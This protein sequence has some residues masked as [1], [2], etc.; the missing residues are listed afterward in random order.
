LVVKCNDL[1]SRL[2]VFL[3]DE[4]LDLLV[5]HV[6]LDPLLVEASGS[7]VEGVR[8]LLGTG[9]VDCLHASHTVRVTEVTWVSDWS[10]PAFQALNQDGGPVELAESIDKCFDFMSVRVLHCAR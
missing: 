4:V 10:F 7:E 6:P 8:Y 5:G 3:I 2:A 1:S 9:S